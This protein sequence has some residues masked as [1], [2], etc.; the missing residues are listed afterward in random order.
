MVLGSGGG[1]VREKGAFCIEVNKSESS[2]Q[3]KITQLRGEASGMDELL[4][5]LCVPSML[6]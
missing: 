2:S 5:I 6:L 3:C 1:E 4:V